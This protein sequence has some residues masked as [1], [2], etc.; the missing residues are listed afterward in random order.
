GMR[1][2]DRGNP[3]AC[4]DRS[5]RLVVDQGDAVPE[6]VP[7]G[8]LD[9]ERALAD[10]ERRVGPDPSQPGLLL[11]D[12]VAMAG[13]QLLERRP[14]LAVRRHPLA[15]VLADRARVRRLRALG[16]LEAAR[17]ADKGGHAGR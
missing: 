2:R 17:R 3:A 16:V 4:L 15:L 13:P 7:G 10:R 6:E 11:L 1:D 14:A 5:D 12:A 9:E 8:R